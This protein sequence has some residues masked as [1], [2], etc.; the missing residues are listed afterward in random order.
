MRVVVVGASG[1]LGTAILRRFRADSTITSVVGVARR[2]PRQAPPPP[3]DV[4]EWVACDISARNDDEETVL[5]TL[6]DAFAGAAAV[7]HLAWAIQPSH[8]RAYQRQVNV[9][10]TRRVVEA[11]RRAGVPHVVVASSVGVYGPAVDD[12]LH[13]ELF[14]AVGVPSSRYSVDKAAQERVLDEAEEAHPDLA[15]ARLR[16]ALVFQRAAG[17]EI[18]GI[19]LGPF[20]PARLLDGRLPVLPWPR[21]VRVQA[22]HADD[23]AEAAREA[24][25]R[26]VRGAFNLAGPG[27]LRGPDV[28]AVLSQAKIREVPRPVARAALSA[29]WHARVAPIDPGWLDL[30]GSVP[31][32]DTSRAEEILAW[33]P[34]YTAVQALQ[35]VVEG[36]AQGVGTASP[37][38]T[39]R[40]GRFVRETTDA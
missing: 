39:P 14:P 18:K 34:R 10:G 22:V 29:A 37:P 4:A 8:A 7:V 21:A 38:L 19:F 32:L 6:S 36:M 20:V 24:V 31:L 35:E 3:Y 17:N 13:D 30:A 33:R 15:I 1:N 28:A 23:L 25:V 2:A 5:R 11:A 16:P 40:R 27:I 12:D 26:Q 9:E